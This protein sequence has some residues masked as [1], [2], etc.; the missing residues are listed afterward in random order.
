MSKTVTIK[1]TI[2]WAQLEIPNDMSGKYQVDL[3]FLSD[4]AATALDGL[5]INV[6]ESDE[7]GSFITC[8]SKYPIWA[9]GVDG[10]DLRG[11]KVGN[12]SKAVA[13]IGAFDWTFKGKSGV[14]PSLDAL[15]IT[16][17]E[18]YEDATAE[19]PNLDEAL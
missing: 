12:G 19:A 8:K 9:K 14:S 6:R 7:K 17:L 2:M 4:A 3:C 10:E 11:V 13:K 1:A 5:G 15:T 18:V 16:E